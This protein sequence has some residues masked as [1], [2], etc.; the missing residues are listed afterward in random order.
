MNLHIR[1]PF[2]SAWQ[3]YGWKK[4]WGI[5]IK[6]KTVMEAAKTDGEPIIITVMG[7]P[8]K[9]IIS[10]HKAVKYGQPYTARLNTELLVIPFNKFSRYWQYWKPMVYWG[11]KKLQPNKVIKIVCPKCGELMVKIYPWSTLGL[12]SSTVINPCK[13]CQNKLFKKWT[14]FG[15]A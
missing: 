3:K 7:D 14:K 10:P 4:T 11:M 8:Q 15:V 9:Y 12:T 13:K 2:F 1:Y 5:G 6:K